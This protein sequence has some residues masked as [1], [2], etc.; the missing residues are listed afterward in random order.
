MK[1]FIAQFE[2]AEW[3]DLVHGETHGK[4]K[5]N[6]LRWNPG[7][8]D[9]G[10]YTMIRLRRIPGL[11]DKPFTFENAKQAGFTYQEEGD[12]EPS[13]SDFIND[14]QCEVCQAPNRLISLG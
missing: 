9:P 4:A 11:D 6:F 5:S 10:D 2:D 1:A 7:T 3:C 14:C 12:E 8:N 13:P